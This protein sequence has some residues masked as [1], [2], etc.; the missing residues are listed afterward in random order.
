MKHVRFSLWI[1]VFFRPGKKHLPAMVDSEGCPQGESS[2]RVKIKG[3]RGDVLRYIAQARP[4][5]GTA[6]TP[7]SIQRV[8][9]IGTMGITAALFVPGTGTLTD[10]RNQL[11]SSLPG[12][13][14][15]KAYGLFSGKVVPPLRNAVYPAH[16][17]EEVD[18]GMLVPHDAAGHG[19]H[20]I[21]IPEGPVTLS[22]FHEITPD[23][24]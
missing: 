7:G 15:G 10:Q 11:V 22:A 16:G 21:F 3:L 2:G 9:E 19:S 23:Y 18:I 13:G 1:L 20:P 6:R 17:A 5:I 14:T 12:E 4:M 8:A 24:S